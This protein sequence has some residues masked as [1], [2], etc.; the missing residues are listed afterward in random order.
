MIERELPFDFAILI[1]PY[2]LPCPH[3]FSNGLQV[4][5]TTFETLLIQHI[6]FNLGYQPHPWQDLRFEGQT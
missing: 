6:Q 3:F 5:D 1:V 2:L 4:R